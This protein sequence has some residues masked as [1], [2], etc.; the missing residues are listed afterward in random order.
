VVI[1]S[2]EGIPR[3]QELL[4]EVEHLVSSANG[5]FSEPGWTPVHYIHRSVSHNELLSLYRAA[6]LVAKEYCAARIEDYGVLILSQFAGAMPELRKGALSVNP[7]DELGVAK[8]LKQ[9]I[10]MPKNDQTR[11]MRSMRRQISRADIHHWRDRFFASLKPANLR[12]ERQ[13]VVS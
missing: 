12:K 4:A 10:E 5:E 1:P 3:Y 11:R 2:R 7:Y 6:N 13:P 8:A 9:A